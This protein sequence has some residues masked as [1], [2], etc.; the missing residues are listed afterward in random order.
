[1]LRPGSL[2]GP[3]DLVDEPD[4]VTDVAVERPVDPV[5]TTFDHVLNRF[6]IR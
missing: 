5:P 3:L 2:T 4:D 6:L 1:M